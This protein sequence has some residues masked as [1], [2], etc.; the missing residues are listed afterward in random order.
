MNLGRIVR[1]VSSQWLALFAQV[2]IALV[3]T[4]FLIHHL[5][6]NGYGIIT[7][8]SGL[9]GYSGVLYLGLGA[10]IIKYVA[11]HHA[12]GDQG[13]L[14]ATVSTI[15][16]VYL[17]VGAA[18]LALALLVA[19]PLPMLFRIPM[20]QAS[21][22]RAMMV[23]MGFA[24]FAQFPGSVFS[25]V[26]MGLERFDAINAISLSL[27]LGRTIA[28]FALVR[29]H[30]SV[31]TVGAVTMAS[32]LVEQA[33]AYIFARRA[34]PTLRC[35]LALFDPLRL[36][37]LFSFSSKSFLFTLSERL[38]NQTDQFVI[39]QALGPAAVTAYAIPLRFVDYAR[40]AI[41]KATLVL[42]PG[43]SAAAARGEYDRLRSLWRTGN[44]AMMMLVFPVALVLV[45]WGHELLALWI[46]ERHATEGVL[47]LVFLALAFVAQVAGRGLARPILEGLAELT[48]AARVT[49][50]E[51]V[52]NLVLSVVLVRVGRWGIAGVALGTLIP[53]TVTGIVVMPWIVCRRLGTSYL[54]HVVS[55]FGATAPPLV[56]SWGVLWLAHR[57]GMHRHVIT[58]GATCLC[59]LVV[60]VA[61]SVF[62]T[63][64]ADER[65]GILA[66][67]RRT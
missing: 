42:M 23:M 18:C 21:A 40:D 25:G 14:N 55:T 4:P 3:M 22:A 61:C 46:D 33:I 13:Q 19:I 15:F 52:A 53:A 30:P 66:Q 31:V 26:L 10:A 63:L 32:F 29:T 60:Y 50:F 28:I 27:L 48:V 11:E 41:D 7:L 38:I 56:P 24:L 43:V 36:R 35:S 64:D 65:A 2:G 57:Y 6:D 54:R 47:S 39:S 45:A 1:N 9:V 37:S 20:G 17:V 62:L 8:V 16:T 59:V 49:V 12:R 44:K 5:G 67:V 58:A 51:G 34:M